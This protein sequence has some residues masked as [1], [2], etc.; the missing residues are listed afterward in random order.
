MAAPSDKKRQV[1]GQQHALIE[2]NLAPRQ[3]PARSVAPAR[4]LAFAD[5]DIGLGLDAIAI[6]QEAAGDRHLLWRGK[7]RLGALTLHV[8]AARRQARALLL[9]PTAAALDHL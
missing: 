1:L 6:D 9:G 5:Q 8:G 2:D 4:I 7:V 3:K